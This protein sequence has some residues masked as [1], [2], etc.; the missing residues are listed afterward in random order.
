MINIVIIITGQRLFVIEI[1]NSF[2]FKSV[3]PI[4][5]VGATDP[6]PDFKWGSGDSFL[7]FYPLR[8][9]NKFK[10]AL[11]L[12]ECQKSQWITNK[13]CHSTIF[14]PESVEKK[15]KNNET[16]E[17]FRFPTPSGKIKQRS[18]LLIKLP[19]MPR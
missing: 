10:E 12:L 11:G 8:K 4:R 18:H 13:S 6:K 7:V 15:V 5:R 19:I 17:S 1:N 3:I 2:K 14:P 9:G 16:V